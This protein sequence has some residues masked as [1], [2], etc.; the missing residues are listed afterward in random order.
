V[1]I[2]PDGNSLAIARDDGRITV[3]DLKTRKFD[4]EL[5]TYGSLNV[6]AF[7]PNGAWI[8]AGSAS[9]SIT[10]WNLNDGRIVTGPSHRGQVFDIAFS[11]DGRKFLSGGSDSVAFV[12]STTTGQK[13]FTITNEDWV[14][15]VTFSP[16]GSWFVT[17]SDDFRV[18]VW[19]TNTGQERLRLLQDSIVSEAKVSPNGQYIAATGKDQTIRV[20]NAI[21]GTEMFQVPL[22]GVGNVLAFSPNGNYLIS[23]DQV[24]G[25][26]IWDISVLPPSIGTLQFDGFVENIQV[27]PSGDWLVASSAGR[28]W[29]LTYARLSTFSG[30]LQTDPAL[31]FNANVAQLVISPDSNWVGISTDAGEISLLNIT[32]RSTKS[33]P[34][35]G[36][37][38]NILFSSDS[39]LLITVDGSLLFDGTAEVKSIAIS[40]NQLALGLTDKILIVDVSS[41]NPISEIQ[42]PGDNGIM[43]FSPDG[44]LFA[45][46]NSSGQLSIWRVSGDEFSLLYT[47]PGEKAD[48]MSFDPQGSRLFTGTVNNLLIYDAL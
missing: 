23:G 27:S 11:P 42:S 26:G 29:L 16:D 32:S 40:S 10:L 25:I 45:S 5:Y 41:G 18:R 4:F 6:T 39:Q 9:G 31:K 3:I 28:V 30:I 17:A 1:N 21:T 24:G 35:N 7:S 22:G 38:K 20:W 36:F 34:K 19:D 13:I 43:V 47:V 37:G 15:D 14:E 12:A 44:T 8:A 33:I 2:S 48:S 46:N